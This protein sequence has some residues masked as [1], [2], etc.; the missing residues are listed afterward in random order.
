MLLQKSQ[1]HSIQ[2]AQSLSRHSFN[3]VHML[4]PQ[5]RI[6]VS[7]VKA[8]PIV[9]DVIIG[10]IALYLIVDIGSVFYKK[11]QYKNR[12]EDD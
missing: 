7:P 1:F 5:K 4:H 11:N 3:T 9:I 2:K 6:L 8:H 12:K 10:S